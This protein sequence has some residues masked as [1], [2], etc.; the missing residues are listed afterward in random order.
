MLR[1]RN[2]IG[3]PCVFCAL[4]KTCN[5]CIFR[6]V[7]T[8]VFSRSSVLIS[9][10]YYNII[11]ILWRA[12]V[13]NGT[14]ATKRRY[15]R[16]RVVSKLYRA[17]CMHIILYCCYYNTTVRSGRVAISRDNITARVY[18]RLSS[19]AFRRRGQNTGYARDFDCFGFAK[20]HLLFF[21][22]VREKIT[23]DEVARPVT[24]HYFD[25]TRRF[26]ELSYR[27]VTVF[28]GI[29][30]W[31]CEC[32]A[33]FSEAFAQILVGSSKCSLPEK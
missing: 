8:R 19:V 11:R 22:K 21:G 20:R 26:R 23:S 3:L 10:D 13:G 15:A 6:I 14:R 28:G 5:V 7:C 32:V 12:P 17:L 24:D 27:S 2:N 1:V 16:I 29:V 30:S 9:N 4:C 18:P 25:E 33:E 31:K